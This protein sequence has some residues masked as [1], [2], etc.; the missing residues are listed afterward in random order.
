VEHPSPSNLKPCWKCNTPNPVIP[1]C[2]SCGNIQDIPEGLTYFALFGL[3]P[4]L[5]MD[6][7]ALRDHYYELSRK[8]HPDRFATAAHPSPGHATRWTTFLNRAYQTLAHRV[9]RSHYVLELAGFS[10]EKPQ[11]VP[12]EL[13]E[14]YFDLQELLVEAKAP[15]PILEFREQLLERLQANELEWEILAERW[16]R[17]SPKTEIATW[18]QEN[19]TKGRYLKSMIADLGKRVGTPNVDIGN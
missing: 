16:T 19:L 10:A 3:P 6:E 17:D 8:L 5:R 15:E 14:Q 7:E 9:P 11:E 12:T 4:K 2:E 1:F 13:A 18:L